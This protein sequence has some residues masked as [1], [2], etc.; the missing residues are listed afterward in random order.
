[1]SR[2]SDTGLKSIGLLLLA[3]ALAGVVIAAGPVV[4]APGQVTASD[5]L[6]FSGPLLAVIVAIAAA[7]L[8]WRGYLEHRDSERRRASERQD[9]TFATVTTEIGKF[10]DSI[11]SIWWGIDRTLDSTGN[12]SL[13]SARRGFTADSFDALPDVE[14]IAEIRLL[15]AQL[16]PLRQHRVL[17]VVLL[18]EQLYYL[19][20]R[21]MGRPPL[22]TLPEQWQLQMFEVCRIH[23]SHIG[24]YVRKLD[25]QFT[26]RFQDRVQMCAKNPVMPDQIAKAK[27]NWVMEEGQILRTKP[28]A[29]S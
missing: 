26:T 25:P 20:R 18:L 23:F 14:K 15:A 2:R 21:V 13:D 9:A 19:R 5:W 8:G 6:F 24:D 10:L 27:A 4:V 1:M 29:R 3:L 28:P 17:S 7:Y 22:G 11:D 12:P 16:D